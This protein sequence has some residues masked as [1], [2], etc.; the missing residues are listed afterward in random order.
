MQNDLRYI[1]IQRLWLMAGTLN[2]D[3]PISKSVQTERK[4]QGS[5]SGPGV[6]AS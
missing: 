4:Q 6:S 2:V 5:Q 3:P 1:P